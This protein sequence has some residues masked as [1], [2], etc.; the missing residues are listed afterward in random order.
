MG[1]RVLMESV[2]SFVTLFVGG[3]P[4]RA[5]GCRNTGARAP[6]ATPKPPPICA[7]GHLPRPGA[8]A[9]HIL[10]ERDA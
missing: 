2:F 6:D 4:L 7:N 3:E 5:W 9:L 8:P 10:P 1:V